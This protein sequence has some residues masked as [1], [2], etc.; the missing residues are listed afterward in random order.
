LLFWL[1]NDFIEHERK[2]RCFPVAGGYGVTAKHTL[3]TLTPS[4]VRFRDAMRTVMN[5]PVF[6]DRTT[7]RAIV[8]QLVRHGH[9]S[10]S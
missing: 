3:E 7:T 8:N 5:M 6:A 9:A 4:H 1:M 2:P 10:S